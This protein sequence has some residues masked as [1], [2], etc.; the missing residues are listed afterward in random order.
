[1]KVLLALLFLIS[2][3]T[4][5]A[6][7][8]DASCSPGDP[9]QYALLLK[10]SQRFEDQSRCPGVIE[11]YVAIKCAPLDETWFSATASCM[12]D[13]L[14]YGTWEPRDTRSYRVNRVTAEILPATK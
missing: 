9:Q 3:T 4:A 13:P 6:A 5:P 14:G 1:M 11:A 8:F 2:S 10:V 7:D 12:W